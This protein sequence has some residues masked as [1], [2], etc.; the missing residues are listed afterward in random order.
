MARTVQMITAGEFKPHSLNER[1]EVEAWM[2]RHWLRPDVTEAL[3]F[4]SSGRVVATELRL[5]NGRPFI[6]LRT[7]DLACV[8]R[9]VPVSEPFPWSM[10]AA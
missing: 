6:D 3:R 7:G 10:E 5:R 4:T 1:A 8:E 9:G 2:A